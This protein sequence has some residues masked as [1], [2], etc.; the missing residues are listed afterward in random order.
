MDTSE[1]C[2]LYISRISDGRSF[3]ATEWRRQAAPCQGTE[4][5]TPLGQRNSGQRRVIIQLDSGVRPWIR[6]FA[7]LISR[8]PRETVMGNYA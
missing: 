3:S 2:L 8:V 4:L 6:R 5:C 7:A 1:I